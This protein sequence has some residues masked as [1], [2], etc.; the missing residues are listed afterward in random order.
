MNKKNNKKNG[1]TLIELLAVIIILGILMIIAIPSVTR[2]ISDSRKSA[3]VDTAK[4]LVSSTRNLVNSGELGMYDTD[5]TYYIPISCIRTENGA[6]SPYGEFI[7]DKT[8]SIV[9]FNGQGYD[10]YWVGL[11]DTGTGV[12]KVINIDDLDIDD[13]ESDLSQEDIKNNIAKDGKDTIA[14]FNSDCT[15]KTIVDAYCDTKIVFDSGGVSLDKNYKCLSD[16]DKYGR[17]PYAT[18]GNY[19]LDSWQINGETSISENDT[20]SKDDFVYLVKGDYDF[21]GSSCLTTNLYLFNET[22]INKNFYISIDITDNSSTERQASIINSKNEKNNK[23][24]G[25]VFRRTETYS[26][27][28]LSVGNTVGSPLSYKNAELPYNTRKVELFRI[29]NVLYYRLDNGEAVSTL[30]FTGFTDYFDVPV[31]IGCSLNSSGNPFRYFKGTLSNI[32]FTFL[33]NDATIENIEDHFVYELKPKWKK[34]NIRVNFDANGGTV[35]QQYMYVTENDYYGK[36]PTPVREGYIFNGWE[37]KILDVNNLT[38]KAIDAGISIDENGYVYDV[39]PEADGRHPGDSGYAGLAWNWY[40]NLDAGEYNFST[41][42]I[43]SADHYGTDLSY[44]TPRFDIR[45]GE[46]RGITIFSRGYG[47]GVYNFDEKTTTFSLQ[48]PLKVGILMKLFDAI[49]DVSLYK[50]INSDSIVENINEHTLRAKWLKAKY[51]YNGDYVFDGTNYIDTG[52]YLFN[53]KN[54]NRNFHISIDITDNSST[55]RQASIINSKNEKN[56]KYPGFVF[57]RTETYSKYEL[58]VGNTVGSPLSYKN[59]ELPYNTR[60]VELFRINNVLYYRLD[61]GEAVSTLDFTGFTDY[62][63][64]P[65]TIGCSLNSSGNPFRYFKGTLSNM[66][67][68]F[69]DDN[70][71]LNDY[72]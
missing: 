67:V 58:S 50:N 26:K 7:K 63:D 55:E 4:Q 43:K 11:D 33:D 36:L 15:D 32:I 16:G 59:A 44:D 47:K 30:D 37:T 2:Y 54:I 5:T 72:Q 65:V 10:Y 45:A 61:N 21:D 56:N 39:T 8:Y 46:G 19:L 20:F 49:V 27:Y 9:T 48:S 17:L 51:E 68:E 64:V 13:I 41:K 60:K 40:E 69:I 31:T 35:N 66:V 38:Q 3:Y 18:N 12:K 42:V 53:E 57:R 70:A 71:T 1:F 62:F 29:N 25:F 22:N 34:T 6:K 24:P 14:I 23:Y 52:I 28:E